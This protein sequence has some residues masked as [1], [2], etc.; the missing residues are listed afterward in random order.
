MQ[1]PKGT[2][3]LVHSSRKGIYH[4]IATEKFDTEKDEWYSIAVDQDKPIQGMSADNV[5]EKGDEIP[6]RRGLCK[7]TI[8]K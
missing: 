1:I 3:L 5:W 6:A 7:V 8:R 2:K 4:G